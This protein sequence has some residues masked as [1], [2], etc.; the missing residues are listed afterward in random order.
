MLIGTN[1]TSSFYER[2]LSQLA[3]L[4]ASAERSQNQIA[5]G[6]RLERGS[7]DPLAASRLRA[8]AR[9]DRMADVRDTNADSAVATLETASSVITQM[10]DRIIRAR[11]LAV[12]AGSNTLGDNDRELIAIELDEIRNSLIDL[13]N[14]TDASGNPLFGGRAPAPA[15]SDDGSGAIVYNGSSEVD[16][17]EIGLGVEIERGVTGPNVVQFSANG[18]QTDA[19][20][21][22]AQLTADL[23]GASADPAAAARDA[24]IGFEGALDSMSRSQTVLGARLAWID[25]V[26]FGAVARDEARTQEQSELG[27]VDLA[28]AITQL[29]QTLTT[30]EAS[31]ASFARVSS[32]SLFD[33]I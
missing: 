24:A 20:A 31:Q 11:E 16:T 2:S 17:V 9:E 15:F 22:I 18:A 1:S 14:Q 3:N 32:L 12:Q 8:L 13:A 27:D 5:T 28:E 29:Q 6:V 7:D 4:R 19:F 10:S 25:T 30:L 26:Q 33:L 21:F 23:R